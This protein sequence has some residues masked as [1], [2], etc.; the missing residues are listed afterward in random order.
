M[1]R[2]DVDGGSLGQTIGSNSSIL[3]MERKYH[4]QCANDLSFCQ[5]KVLTLEQGTAEAEMKLKL[6]RQVDMNKF[7]NFEPTLH[8][9]HDKNDTLKAN[10]KSDEN[11]ETQIVQETEK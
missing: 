11:I 9:S 1:M 6:S 4:P 3:A 2:V 7:V 10:E 5:E 8:R